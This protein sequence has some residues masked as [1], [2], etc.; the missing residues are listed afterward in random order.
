MRKLAFLLC[1]LLPLSVMAQE[2]SLK[3]ACS[4]SEGEAA[5]RVIYADSGEFILQGAQ[6]QEFRWESSL[7]RATHGFDCSLDQSDGLQAEV[8]EQGWRV[9]VQDPA[10]AREQRGYDRPRGRLCTVRLLREGE[11]LHVL[12]SCATL[13]GSRENFSEFK[14][15]LPSKQCEYM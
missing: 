13:C 10:R 1:C 4:K 14:I 5:Q 3:F 6:L 11:Y 8:I 9:K 15:H 12:P 7:H 2:L